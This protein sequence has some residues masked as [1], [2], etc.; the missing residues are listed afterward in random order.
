MAV[1]RIAERCS[2]SSFIKIPGVAYTSS[3][4]KTPADKPESTGNLTN[5]NYLYICIISSN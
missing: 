3:A 1:F 4:A 5:E 2:I